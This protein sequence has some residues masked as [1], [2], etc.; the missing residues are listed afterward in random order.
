MLYLCN[1]SVKTVQNVKYLLV[2]L[3]VNKLKITF[4]FE[5][6]V[7]V[8]DGVFLVLYYLLHIII[9]CTLCRVS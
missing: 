2:V 6:E 5:V 7:L 4:I 1:A 9:V 8:D 3:F